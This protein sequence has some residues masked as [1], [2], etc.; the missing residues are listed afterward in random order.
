MEAIVWVLLTTRSDVH[1]Y[2]G[3]DVTTLW[4]SLNTSYYVK[5]PM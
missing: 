5:N 3:Q 4:C 1:K 2:Q